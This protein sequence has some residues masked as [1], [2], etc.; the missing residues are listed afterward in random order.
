MARKIVKIHIL[1]LNW[2][3]LTHLQELYPTLLNA[4]KNLNATWYVRDNGSKDNSL[5]WLKDNKIITLDA[6]HNRSSFSEGS[7]SLYNL[8]CP[9]KDDYLLFLNN[10]IIFN[11]DISLQK[12]VDLQKYTNAG[13][14]GARL[15]YKNTN[16][17]QFAGTIFSKR[18]NYLPYHYRPGEE[19]DEY[20]QKN[21]YFQA[22]T[23]ACMLI[24]VYI[25]EKAGKFNLNYKWAFEDV[26]LCLKIG[27]FSKVAY[28]GE[29]NIFHEE[30]YSLKKNPVNKMFL[31]QN[32]DQFRKDWSGKYKLDLELYQKNPDY[33]IIK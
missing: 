7:N 6:G 32:V 11:D 9:K 5:E 19:S 14:V 28:C 18:Y 23:A 21:R 24:P 27:Q 30:S 17:L 15:L 10:D 4:T 8:A 33:N 1:T 22:V 3:G 29:T 25:F 13:V 12:M 16:K 31:K 20:A 2:N 26:S